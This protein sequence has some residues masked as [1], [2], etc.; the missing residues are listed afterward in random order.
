MYELLDAPTSSVVRMFDAAAVLTSGWAAPINDEGGDMAPSQHP[1]R[2]RVR[3][4]V[5]VCDKGVASVLRFA[6]TPDD[7]ITDAGAARGSLADAVTHLW[8]D[9][10]VKA[11]RR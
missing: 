4:V 9:P 2:R 6:D 7:V 3:L 8:F 10:P 5:V 1:E 11:L